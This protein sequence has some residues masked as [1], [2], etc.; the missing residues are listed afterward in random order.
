M[1]IPQIVSSLVYLSKHGFLRNQKY[2]GFKNWPESSMK[3]CKD[4]D[5][6]ALADSIK[7]FDSMIIDGVNIIE[8]EGELQEVF[9]N[10]NGGDSLVPETDLSDPRSE[11][12]RL[13]AL[14]LDLSEDIRAVISEKDLRGEMLS[15][16]IPLSRATLRTQALQARTQFGLL[17]GVLTSILFGI[18]LVGFMAKSERPNLFDF[19]ARGLLITAGGGAAGIVIAHYAAPEELRSEG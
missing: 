18:L 9:P 15:R 10:F 19:V 17:C 3:Q 12:T 4:V 6:D 13:N 2:L 5:L 7:D 16:G 11:K 8:L 14:L 1:S